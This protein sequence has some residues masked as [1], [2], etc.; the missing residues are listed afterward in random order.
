[1]SNTASPTAAERLV[2]QLPLAGIAT[3]LAALMLTVIMITF[4][5]FQPGGAE[6]SGEGGDIVNQ[7]G[8]GTLGIAAIAG[9]GALADRRTMSALVSPWWLLLLA[10]LALSVL[11]ALDPAAAM[12]TASFTLIGILTMA[13]VLALPRDA[14]AFSTVLAVAGF[15]I[16]GLSYAGLVLFPDVAVHGG[17][18]LEPQHAGF[19]RGAFTHK[20]IAGPVMASLSFAGLYLWRRGRR[21]GLLLFLAA[22]V[23]MANTGSKTTAGT[24][25]LA[26]LLVV[27]PGLVGMRAAV[28]LLLAFGLAGAAIGTVGIVLI[29]PVGDIAARIAPDL[30]YTGRLSLWE[31]LREMIAERPWFGYGYASFWGTETVYMTDQPFDRAWDIRGIVHG[32]NSYLDLAAYMGLPALAVALVTLVAVPMLDY[33]RVPRLKEN[34]LMADFFMM[35]LVFTLL[36]AFLESFFFRRADPVWL[37]LVMA[38][39]GLRLVARL[40]IKSR[41]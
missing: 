32:H 5:P 40:P 16:V 6:L 37:F 36:N 38:V 4:R 41:A 17:D 7:L 34:V 3:T 33:L 30:T 13:A 9:L 27:L 35:I 28:P 12:R 23:F 24:V 18:G 26:M 8:F 39:L 1:M 19:W 29:E 20:N 11:N 14:E 31:F 25:P 22:M 2:A 10:F 21:G 15:T